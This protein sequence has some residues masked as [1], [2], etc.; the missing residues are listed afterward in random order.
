MEERI[1][2]I[3]APTEKTMACMAWQGVSW[4]LKD[5]LSTLYNGPL[6]SSEQK[7][8]LI[9]RRYFGEN[10]NRGSIRDFLSEKRYFYKRKKRV[11]LLGLG[12]V[13]M[14]LAIGLKLIG[15]DVISD[16]GLFDISEAQKTRMEIELGQ[17][18]IYPEMT[19]HAIDE[20][21]LFDCDVFVFCA[22]K[23]VPPVGYD[24]KDVRMI[25]LEANAELISIY[26]T[27]AKRAGFKGIFAVVSDP[28]DL[29]CRV[30]YEVAGKQ[31][32]SSSGL[33]PEQIRG[34]GLGVMDGRASFYSQRMGLNYSE[35]GR[36][37][38]PHGSGL[39]VS[40]DIFVPDSEKSAMLTRTVISANLEVRELGF[41]PYIA[42]AIASGAA[43]IAA[44]L[45]GD[46]H[47]SATFIGG[48]FWGTRNRETAYGTAYERLVLDS[49]LRMRIEA[50][51]QALEATWQTFKQA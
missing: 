8:W 25:Q 26:A 50:S 33:L 2:W 28:V 3:D 13:G 46:W 18:P 4:N 32:A 41:K 48:L 17:I 10:A 51:Y 49:G 14:T 35:S 15:G 42:P 44:M 11:N 9:N 36:V 40:D 6:F 24:V 37:F 30:V 34:F 31:S 23:G 7:G 43:S 5:P 47:Y 22:S 16:L 27:R 21:G 38:G 1:Y 12:D 39:I 29:L 45:R 19:V 20:A